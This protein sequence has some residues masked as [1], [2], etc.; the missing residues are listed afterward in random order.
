MGKLKEAMLNQ[1]ET[2]WESTPNGYLTMAR[3]MEGE[4]VRWYS[5]NTQFRNM[6]GMEQIMTKEAFQAGFMAGF[7]GRYFRETGND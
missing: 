3:I 2:E 4:W 5:G 6:T 1:E 7:E